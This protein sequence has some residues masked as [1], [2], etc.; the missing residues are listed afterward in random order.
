MFDYHIVALGINVQ[1]EVFFKNFFKPRVV[2]FN[3][4]IIRV[5]A[6]G[7]MFAKFFNYDGVVYTQREKY[8]FH[9]LSCL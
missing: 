5:C 4:D 3:Y 1:R 2:I 6:E 7:G 8:F 9:F